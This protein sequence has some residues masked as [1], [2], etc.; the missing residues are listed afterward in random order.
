MIFHERL[1]A[2]VACGDI[3]V[4]FS[5]NFFNISK[6]IKDAFQTQGSQ[7]IISG[8]YGTIV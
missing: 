6:Y 4:K 3:H 7:N 2:H 8:D 1:C 5:F